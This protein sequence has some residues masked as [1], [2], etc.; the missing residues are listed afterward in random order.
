MKK[1]ARRNK[2]IVVYVVVDAIENKNCAL[3]RDFWQLRQETAPPGCWHWNCLERRALYFDYV[4]NVS[5]SIEVISWR[6]I[7]IP[8]V[9]ELHERVFLK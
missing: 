8:V 2:S 7:Y 3:R 9:R 1:I 5:Q 4:S 6:T